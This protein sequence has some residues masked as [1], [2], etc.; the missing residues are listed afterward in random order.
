MKKYLVTTTVPQVI[1]LFTLFV[2][3]LVMIG[4]TQN[5]STIVQILPHLAPMQ[6]NTALCFFLIG[7]AFWIKTLGLRK[8][9]FCLAVT[10]IIIPFLTL[11]QYFLGVSFGIDELFIRHS[12]E[13]RTSHPGRMSPNTA[14]LFILSGLALAI[15]TLK[16]LV[17]AQ[18]I[19]VTIATVIFV[20]SLGQL[21]EY[22]F[23]VEAIRGWNAFSQ[24][25]LHTTILFFLLSIGLFLRSLSFSREGGASQWIYL[26]LGFGF[27]AVGIRSWDTLFLVKENAPYSFFVSFL[28]VLSLFV[29]CAVYFLSRLFLSVNA[30]ESSYQIEHARRRFLTT[31]ISNTSKH[32]KEPLQ[33]LNG[34][35]EIIQSSQDLEK[36]KEAIGTAQGICHHLNETCTLLQEYG[37]T[38]NADAQHNMTRVNIRVWIAQVEQIFLGRF[39]EEGKQLKLNV[40]D[41][42]PES[43]EFDKGNAGHILFHILEFS[44]FLVA[45]KSTIEL[46][47]SAPTQDQLVVTI[48][49]PNFREDVRIPSDFF[50]NQNVEDI[51]QKD[52]FLRSGLVICRE[53]ARDMNAKI[54]FEKTAATGLSL[55][56][57]IP[58][59]QKK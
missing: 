41:T 40:Q 32:V 51:A 13:V 27:F 42:V 45:E 53:Y 14:L 16:H 58:I 34:L 15:R 31:L 4:W 5:S 50:Q 29:L 24:M 38:G 33:T 39:V 28:F 1:S 48:F 25:A 46:E 56:L 17:S 2:S 3:L 21:L 55:A 43:G 10:A 6:F 59:S 8:T 12:I 52:F 20:V 36:V 44:L 11:T 49:V 19:A 54:T 23:H 18:Y 30:I 35:I 9:A 57:R 47:V 26:A 37:S 22:A 7:V